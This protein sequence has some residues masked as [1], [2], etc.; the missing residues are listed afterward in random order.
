[1]YLNQVVNYSSVALDS[2]RALLIVQL[3]SVAVQVVLNLVLVPHFGVTGAA[4]A[5]LCSES[6]SLLGSCF[7]FQRRAGIQVMFWRGWRPIAVAVVVALNAEL[8]SAA[9]TTGSA[10]LNAIIGGA[11]VGVIYLAVAECFGST[12]PEIVEAR[13]GLIDRLRHQRSNPMSPG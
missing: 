12:P 3:P 2:Y 10:I 13:R 4:I 6:C 9:W 8:V 5:L 7:V 11:I 1:M